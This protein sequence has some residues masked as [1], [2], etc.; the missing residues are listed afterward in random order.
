MAPKS[1]NNHNTATDGQIC[2][3]VAKE[4]RVI[5]RMSWKQMD[6][7]EF[8]TLFSSFLQAMA[9]YTIRLSKIQ[10][11]KCILKQKVALTGS[12][13][14]HFCEKVG[15]CWKYTKKRWR[16]AGTGA[17]MPVAMKKI[18]Q[19]WERS[20]GRSSKFKKKRL[21]GKKKEEKPGKSI[22]DEKQ[23]AGESIMQSAGE[24][25]KDEMQSAGESIKDEMAAHDQEPFKIILTP[26][27]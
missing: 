6:P 2:D 24:S 20:H 7:E 16:D 21:W 26:K 10:L 17:H 22:K 19:R 8:G 27:S 23:S 9:T 25:I 18:C 5:E 11:E 1:W 3:L 14:V 13:V 4:I 15:N 12:E